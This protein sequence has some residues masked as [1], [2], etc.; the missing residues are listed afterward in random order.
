MVWALG[1]TYARRSSLEARSPGLACTILPGKKWRLPCLEIRSYAC[2]VAELPCWGP[3]A[4]NNE[5][6]RLALEKGANPH[7]M[8][9]E[10]CHRAAWR[11]LLPASLAAYYSNR[12]RRLQGWL[13]S[14][15][16]CSHAPES[17]VGTARWACA[18]GRW[19]PPV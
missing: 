1:T 3:C 8:S 16:L 11:A 2:T 9:G 12:R 15:I 5:I 19:G 7:T 13:V 10:C 17:R 6:V 18:S 4:G 14:A